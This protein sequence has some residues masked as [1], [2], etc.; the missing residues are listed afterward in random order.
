MPLILRM[1]LILL[2]VVR[3]IALLDRSRIGSGLH[4]PRA[5][6]INAF[7]AVPKFAPGKFSNWGKGNSPNPT[8]TGYIKK[9]RQKPGSCKI[10]SYQTLTGTD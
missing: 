5:S 6:P 1:R 8:L 2:K 3:T 4:G 9:T 7:A 10:I